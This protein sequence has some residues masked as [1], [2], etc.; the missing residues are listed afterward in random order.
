MMKQIQQIKANQMLLCPVGQIPLSLTDKQVRQ[1]VDAK[2][3]DTCQGQK[4]ALGFQIKANQIGIQITPVSADQNFQLDHNVLPDPNLVSIRPGHTLR[5][6]QLGMLL[7]L[8]QHSIPSLVSL[9]GEPAPVRS[10]QRSH[11]S[12][13]KGSPQT[14]VSC[15]S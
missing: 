13:Y 15:G 9:A 14:K 3:F 5:F 1:P 11:F 8:S 6:N 2:T 7:S 12:S 10:Q 4:F